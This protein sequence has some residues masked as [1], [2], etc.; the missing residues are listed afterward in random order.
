MH[1]VWRICGSLTFVIT[2]SIVMGELK[3]RLSPKAA[4]SSPQ[5]SNRIGLQLSW[6]CVLLTRSDV[7]TELGLDPAQ[8]KTLNERLLELHDDAKAIAR[9]SQRLVA[10]WHDSSIAEESL[11]ERCEFL[12]DDFDE[13]LVDFLDSSQ[14]DRLRRLQIQTEGILAFRRSEVIGRL[15]LSHD[16]LDRLEAVPPRWF[17]RFASSNERMRGQSVLPKILT[18]AQIA[19]WQDLKGDDFSFEEELGI[20]K[21]LSVLN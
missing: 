16:Q 8:L 20:S 1:C 12:R 21:L 5:I 15:S 13:R 19:Q 4:H 11:R 18:S 17:N 7:Q 3:P 9:Q 14:L 6:F 10:N 2:L